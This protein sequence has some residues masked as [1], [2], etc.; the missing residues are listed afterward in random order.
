MSVNS[1]FKGRLG[2]TIPNVSVETTKGKFTLHEY[3]EG[4]WGVLFSHPR[5]FTPVCTTELSEVQ[6]FLPEFSK[7]NVKCLAVSCDDVA[8]HNSWIPDICA[9]SGVTG[10]DYPIIGDEKRTFASLFGMLDPEFK[11]DL[12]MPLTVRSVFVINPQKKVALTITYPPPCGRNFHEI[13]RVIDALQLTA[14]QSVATPVNWKAGDP[15]VILPN[16]TSEEAK[17]KFPLGFKKLDLPSG[18]E[19]LRLTPD[20]RSS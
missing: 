2:E 15:T 13:I 4:S 10:I 6:K 7:R 18:K 20:P 8:S 16:I 17:T 19:Y 12:G 5:D 14:T 9:Y 1:V 11:D 3:F